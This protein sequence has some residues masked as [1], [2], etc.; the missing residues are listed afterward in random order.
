MTATVAGTRPD[1]AL[2]ATYARGVPHEEFARR[3]RDE[4][5]GWV[6]EPVLVRHTAGGRTTMRGPG[7]WAV[8]RYADVVAASRRVDDFSSA[9]KGAFLTDPRTPADLHQARQLLV[10]MDDPHHARL[11]KVLTSVFT[12]RAVR[13]LHG[14]IAEHAENL[15][16]KVVAAGEFDVVADLAA[17]LPLLV[18]ADLLGVPKRDR[19]LLYRWSNQLVGFD[20][21]EFGG[22]DIDAYRAAMGEAFQYALRLGMQRR[23]E[24]RDDLVSLLV[25][26]EVDGNRLTDREFCSFWLLLV[27]AGN[28]TTRHLISGS[29]QA[30]LEHPSERARLVEGQVPMDSAVEEMLRWVTPIMQFRRTAIRDTDIGGQPIAAG[31]KVVLYYTSANR[32][33]T[34]FA[35]PDR[36]DLGRSTNRHLSFGIGP[37][38]CLGAH[39]ARVELATLLRALSPHLPS[40]RLTD[41]PSRLESNFVNGVKAMPAAIAR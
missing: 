18:L 11:R 25:N 41:Q 20:D 23:A 12:P 38:Y 16:S 37:H 1:I 34:V 35:E 39:L 5:V 2:P 28:E 13:A 29:L 30:L 8:T 33:A 7:F 17:E 21:P 22:G 31:D 9:A 6:P 40:L 14:S 3:R 36:L 27:V 15:V 4:P 26:A 10:N 24:P 32:D 19:G